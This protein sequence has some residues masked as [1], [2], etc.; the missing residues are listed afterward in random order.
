VLRQQYE[1]KISERQSQPGGES[2]HAVSL[3]SSID[4]DLLESLVQLG[5]FDCTITTVDNVT[6][7]HLTALVAKGSRMK[8]T[9]LSLEQIDRVITQR[10]TMETQD[11][12]AEQRMDK[13][14][15]AYFL[16]LREH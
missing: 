3:K 4:P 5:R 9:N 2:L 13:L 11:P 6:E 14:F 1:A 7:A 16:I 12:D 10:L 15:A 8:L